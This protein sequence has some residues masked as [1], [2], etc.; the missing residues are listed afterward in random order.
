MLLKDIK[1]SYLRTP[2]VIE[3]Y[4]IVKNEDKIP[5]EVLEVSIKRKAK[6]SNL[7][8][9]KQEFIQMQGISSAKNLEFLI[10]YLELDY[11]DRIYYKNKYYDIK[12]IENV[13]EKNKYLLVLG[14]VIE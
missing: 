10:M 4:K 1:S 11:T 3:K 5:I 8:L 2:I 6:V 9:R 12:G 14:E 7:S 13:E